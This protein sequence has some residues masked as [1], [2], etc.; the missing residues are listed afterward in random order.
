MRGS[1]D[2]LACHQW[3]HFVWPRTTTA[4]P[5]RVDKKDS[6]LDS[7]PSMVTRMSIL[8]EWQYPDWRPT[9]CTSNSWPFSPDI[10]TFEARRAIGQL[11]RTLGEGMDPPGLDSSEVEPV[12]RYIRAAR[13]LERIMVVVRHDLVAEARARGLTWEAIGKSEGTGRTAAHNAH[14]AGLSAG[15]LDQLRTEALVS[16]MARQAVKPHPLPEEVASGLDGVS[17]LER[18]EYIAQQAM[19][20]LSEIDGLVARAQ[21]DPGNALAVLEGPCRRIELAMKAVALDHV[22]WGAL[23]GWPGEPETV[24]QVDYHAPTAYLMHAM[25]LLLFALLHAPKEN[26][27]EPDQYRSFLAWA[28]QAYASVLLILER[29]DVGN[30]VPAPD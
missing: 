17:P 27:A 30:A 1:R 29:P 28:G 2:C 3:E 15:R 13:D 6:P 7:D 4:C 24:D 21:S 19:Q 22:M 8:E 12:L 14:K 10:V 26:C 9:P 25:R 11:V 20:T 5:L 23:A 16:W 18:L